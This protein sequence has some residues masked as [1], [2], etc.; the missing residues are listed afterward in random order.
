M[1]RIFVLLV[2]TWTAVGAYA[3]VS[4]AAPGSVALAELGGTGPAGIAADVPAPGAP[5][6]YTN[7]SP[8]SSAARKSALEDGG[9]SG[10][11]AEGDDGLPTESEISAAVNAQGFDFDNIGIAITYFSPSGRK[12]TY[13]YNP[14]S[15][16]YPASTSKV[17][18][19]A[20]VYYYA[21]L[22][23]NQGEDFNQEI[24]AEEAPYIYKM[25]LSSDNDATT[26]LAEKYGKNNIHCFSKQVLGYDGVETGWDKL[27][28]PDRVTA[29]G[30]NLLVSYIYDDRDAEAI[31]LPV[32]KEI[33]KWLELPKVGQLGIQNKPI[34]SFLNDP[35]LPNPYDQ[36]SGL[37]VGMKGG[38]TDDV[39]S[40]YVAGF[41]WR[42]QGSRWTAAIYREGNW[43]YFGL[44]GNL[45][46]DLF[47]LFRDKR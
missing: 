1:K 19:L 24:I 31:P 28:G 33:R 39:G 29:R 4:Y 47:L 13:Q 9:V 40:G 46:R 37:S 44:I 32:K 42:P 23:R 6:K 7:L 22:H 12:V 17:V 45:Y 25:I 11:E 27:A 3:A 26:R 43:D 38:W 35:D 20:Y 14:D 2:L 16:W 15:W 8:R 10:D 21:Y 34:E 41:T 18:V 36:Q 5:A 30:M